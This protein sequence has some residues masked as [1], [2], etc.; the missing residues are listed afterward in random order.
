MTYSSSFRAYLFAIEYILI[1]AQMNTVRFTYT[2]LMTTAQFHYTWV[3]IMKS[4]LKTKKT[5][6]QATCGYN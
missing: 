3:Q 6:C 5:Y 1:R 2:V 4:A